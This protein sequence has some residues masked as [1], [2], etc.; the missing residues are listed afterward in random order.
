MKF[1]HY[2]PFKRPK[3]LDE[4]F[5]NDTFG[6]LKDVGKSKVSMND[7]Q[8]I[9]SELEDIKE[10]IKEHQRL[11]NE[12][13]HDFKEQIL[14]KRYQKVLSVY[15]AAKEECQALLPE[16]QRSKKTEKISRTRMT[17]DEVI[18]K[19]VADMQS[20]VFT[21]LES[22]FACDPLGLLDN[23]GPSDLVVEHEYWRDTAAYKAKKMVIEEPVAKAVKCHE[24]DKFKRYFNEVKLLL[25]QN[26][27]KQ[28]KVVGGEDINVLPGQF[29]V[30]DGV[31]SLIVEGSMEGDTFKKS[32]GKRRY[33]VRQIFDN[34]TESRP[35]NTSVKASFYKSVPP[36]MRLVENDDIGREFFSRLVRE[37]DQLF[38]RLDNAGKP[39][40]YVYILGTLSTEPVIQKFLEH[41]HLIKIGYTSNTVEERIANAQNE[42]TYLCAPVKVLR[43][44]ACKNFDALALE[45]ALHTIFAAHRLNVTLKDNE[46]H[47][48]KPKEWFT[49]S[50]DTACE[51]VEHIM[52]Q[53][54][55]K[56]YIDPI[57]GRLKLKQK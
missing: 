34:G 57:Q 1:N 53:D 14:F 6:L 20:R 21:D 19:E 30:I 25:K 16:D 15:S 47:T 7:T 46:G 13:S 52:A 41:S 5:N 29:F 54:L 26:H 49:V 51:V 35:F 31:L 11:P 10:F 43:T 22:V 9:M 28:V 36:C 48:Y 18:K 50:A 55:N 33:R 42:S 12:A 3:S 44:I 39:D 32:T 56:Y 40:G 2:L 4:I 24:F 8:K 23:V 37:L 27:V 38:E 45:N 17:R